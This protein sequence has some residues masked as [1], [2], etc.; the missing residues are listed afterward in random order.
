MFISDGT[1]AGTTLLKEIQSS[2]Q[3]GSNPSSKTLYNGQIYFS[4]SNGGGGSNNG[5]EMWITDGTNSGTNLF[6]DINPGISS[7]FPEAFH[8]HNGLLFFQANDGVNGRELWV[9]DG[10]VAGTLMFA[11]INP[12]ASNGLIPES[13]FYSIQDKMYFAANDGTNGMELWMYDS[14]TNSV[15]MIADINPSGDSSPSGFTEMNGNLFFSAND[16]TNGFELHKLDPV[17]NQ[18]STI[19]HPS[20]R[21]FVCNN[22]NRHEQPVVFCRR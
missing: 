12:G 14:N 17:T 20:N 3:F 18:V 10:T 16:G 1:E 9:T 6:L 13:N 22:W 2:S 19:R 7:S 11:D 15:Q 4:A 21:F 8:E 5:F